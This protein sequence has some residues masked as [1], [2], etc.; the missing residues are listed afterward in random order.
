[1]DDKMIKIKLAAEMAQVT[2]KTIY[3][4]IEHGHLKLAHPGFVFEADLRRAII[5]VRNRKTEQAQLRSQK[6]ERD[7]S[8]KFRLLSGDLN[9]K[10]VSGL[11]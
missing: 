6:F 8:G 5:S 1:M 7:K 3:S 11:L 2:E 4:W 9:G 10:N